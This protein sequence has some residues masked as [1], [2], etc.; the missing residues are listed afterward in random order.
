MNLFNI[1]K[2]D[3]NVFHSHNS[4]N[5][6]KTIEEDKNQA[7]YSQLDV[8]Y[9]LYKIPIFTQHQADNLNPIQHNSWNI[10]QHNVG[11]LIQYVF[12]SLTFLKYIT[13]IF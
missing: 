9:I 8:K 12:L 1:T 10:K 2:C 11:R 4:D 6:P 7:H 5:L 13:T 3:Q